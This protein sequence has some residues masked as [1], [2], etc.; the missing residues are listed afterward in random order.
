LDEEL[1]N[2]KMKKKRRKKKKKKNRKRSE[3]KMMIARSSNRSY[4]PVQVSTA[5]HSTSQYGMERRRI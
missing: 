1:N 2:G 5:H 4:R 3:M